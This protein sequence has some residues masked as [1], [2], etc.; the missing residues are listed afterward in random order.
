MKE[1]VSKLVILGTCAHNEGVFLFCLQ[2]EREEREKS[3]VADPTPGCSLSKEEGTMT[4]R[5]GKSSCA[6]L[7]SKQVS[8]FLKDHDPSSFTIL[9]FIFR[10]LEFL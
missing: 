10:N 6:V 3:I 2:K 7:I 9:L 5:N 1:E 8:L 4:I